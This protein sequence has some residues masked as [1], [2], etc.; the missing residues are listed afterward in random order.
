MLFF[1]G[2]YFLSIQFDII[3]ER[4]WIRPLYVTLYMVGEMVGSLVGGYIGDR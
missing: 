4:S 3:C 1:K 2:Y